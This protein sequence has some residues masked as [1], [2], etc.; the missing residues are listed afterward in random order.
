MC[1]WT[2]R[3]RVYSLKG[4]FT[5][6]NYKCKVANYFQIGNPFCDVTNNSDNKRQKFPFRSFPHVNGP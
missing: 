3:L 4:P 2:I 5:L 1:E 6:S